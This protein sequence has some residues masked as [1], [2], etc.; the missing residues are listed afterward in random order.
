MSDNFDVNWP[1][2]W[3]KFTRKQIF[4]LK[5]LDS[6]F[7]RALVPGWRPFVNKVY[8]AVIYWAHII[9]IECSLTRKILIEQQ[10]LLSSVLD[11]LDDGKIKKKI[12]WRAAQGPV[13]FFKP[14]VLGNRAWENSDLPHCCSCCV[15]GENSAIEP[16]C[17]GCFTA[18]TRSYISDQLESC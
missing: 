14:P 1:V 6:M 12:E 5:R 8:S 17:C 16:T 7:G 13:S 18:K 15:N 2:N 11:Y 3:S 9:N 4:I 10:S